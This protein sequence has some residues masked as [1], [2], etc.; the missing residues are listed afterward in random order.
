MINPSCCSHESAKSAPWYGKRFYLLLLATVLLY[1]FSAH[2][3]QLF[4]LHIE[5]HRYFKML[6]WP[7]ALGLLLGGAVDYYVPHTYIS[8]HLARKSKRTVLYAVSLGF[9]M[10][11]CSHGILA[12]SMELHKK[13][14]SGP[15]VIAFLLASPWASM[16]ITILLISFFG[17]KA[18]VIIFSALL[19]AL[20]TGFIFQI[21]EKKG[22]I[23]SNRHSVNVPEG[24]SVRKDVARRFR[25]YRLSPAQ[26]AKDF[27]GILSGANSLLDM[28]AW[29]VILGAILASVTGAFVPQKIFHDYFGPTLT[30]LLVT[31]VFATILEVCSECTSPLAFELYHHTGAFGNTFLFL[32][33]GVVT[34]YTQIGL[35][36]SHLGRRTALWMLAVTIP[37]VVLLGWI[38]NC[39]F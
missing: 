21:F 38:Y 14:A 30:G 28:V 17:W 22:W 23:E 5:L 2:V 31:L 33:A 4:A 18:F 37:Q 13:G 16:P 25:G 3:S 9:M 6:F 26:L 34:N 12:L 20:N 11:A 10:S 32:M 19:I 35:V 1:F 15:A 8:K 7:V 29:W 39:V 36:W 27:R 24:F